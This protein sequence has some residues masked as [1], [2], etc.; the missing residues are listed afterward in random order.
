MFLQPRQQTVTPPGT[1]LQSEISSSHSNS[2]R[3]SGMCMRPHAALECRQRAASCRECW[4]DV[5]TFV[6]VW[7]FAVVCLS[8][9]DRQFRQG[10]AVP[11]WEGGS[12]P[13]ISPRFPLC[14]VCS[15]SRIA[16]DSAS[17]LLPIV[18]QLE[19]GFLDFPAC[20][21]SMKGYYNFLCKLNTILKWHFSC[22]WDFGFDL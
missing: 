7:S 9:A 10:E 2:A 8:L 6:P 22:H 19:K 20:S 21:G 4:K 3:L 11:G 13:W 1:S 5:E 16:E 14:P 17:P 15:S 18:H 12:G